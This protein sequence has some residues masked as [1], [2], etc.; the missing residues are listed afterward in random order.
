MI[1]IYCTYKLLMPILHMSVKMNAC[2]IVENTHIIWLECTHV[3]CTKS[4]N[5]CA[6]YKNYIL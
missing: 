5:G 1:A 2:K 4:E 6:L 3:Q